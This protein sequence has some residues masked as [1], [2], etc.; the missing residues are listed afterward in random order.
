MADRS[1]LE[2]CRKE[3]MTTDCYGFCSGKEGWNAGRVVRWG[4]Q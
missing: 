1:G 2:D 3:A 4:E